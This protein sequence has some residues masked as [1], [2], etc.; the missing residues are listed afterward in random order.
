MLTRS[1]AGFR[2]VFSKEVNYESGRVYRIL[3]SHG[4]VNARPINSGVG[5]GMKILGTIA[6]VG[7]VIAIGVAAWHTA[8]IYA[9]IALV[10]CGGQTL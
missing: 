10:I 3:A 6:T 7:A 4:R 9:I 5:T 1:R 8:A 2:I